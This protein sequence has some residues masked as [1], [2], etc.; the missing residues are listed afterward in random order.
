MFSSSPPEAAPIT[1]VLAIVRLF[2]RSGEIEA[3][4]GKDTTR[5]IVFTIVITAI[6]VFRA[7]GEYDALNEEIAKAILK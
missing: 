2:V 6:Y 5:V 4:K 7:N 3:V 1:G